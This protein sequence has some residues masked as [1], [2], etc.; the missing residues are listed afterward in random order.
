M[1]EARYFEKD[2]GGVVR[3]WQI[4]RD[5]I[6]CHM[7]WGQVG[8]RTQRTSMTLDD[9]THAR[10][11]FNK[12]VTEKRRQGYVEVTSGA[13]AQA[14]AADV[15]ADAKLLDVMWVQ[16]EKRY[17]GA[18]DVYW[19][20]YEP[21]Q[22]YE[23]VFA[24]FHDFQGGP[25]PFYDY[26]ALSE[27]ERRGL[28]FVVK[29]PG[30]DPGDIAAFLDF[31]RPRLALA[32]DGRSHHKVPLPYLVGQFDHVL[33]CAP[34]L[35]GNRYGGRLGRAIPILDCEICDEDTETFVEVRIQGRNSM[36]CNTW[37]REPF[38][39]IDL[40]FD[41]R[42]ENGFQE[43]GGNPS[44]REKAFKVYPR[45]MLERGMR[46]LS[47]AL[48]SSWLEIRNYRRDVLTLTRADLTQRTP[49]EINRFLLGDSARA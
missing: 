11:H 35:C 31:I 36:P 45:S 37:D 7:A 47:E 6:R 46:L 15:M 1:S 30:R 18:W 49:A 32:F 44:V 4:S 48:P 33:F 12:K 8:G 20:G 24:K 28:H 9:E 43:L 39:V 29:K 17:E 19:A 23:G 41:L 26:L 16:E 21:V 25:G 40:K 13:A 34:S 22:G 27:D 42:S 2:S 10:R 3:H 38:P 5:G 14:A